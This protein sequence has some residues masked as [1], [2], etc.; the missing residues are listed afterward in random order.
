M[1]SDGRFVG[2]EGIL[3]RGVPNQCLSGGGM[4]S[5]RGYCVRRYPFEREASRNA[6]S[7]HPAPLRP[8]CAL[9]VPVFAR[10]RFEALQ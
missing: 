7:F 3:R 4:P 1:R 6:L 2:H 9:R 5:P 10:R 8:A